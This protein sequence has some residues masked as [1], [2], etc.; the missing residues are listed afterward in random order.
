MFSS[1]SV[2]LRWASLFQQGPSPP[3][4]SVA[5]REGSLLCLRLTGE[6]GIKAFIRAEFHLP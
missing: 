2:I 6:E 3:D 1:I 5:E 4:V